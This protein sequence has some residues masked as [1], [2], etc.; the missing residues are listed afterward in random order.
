[1]K[2]RPNRNVFPFPFPMPSKIAPF[3]RLYSFSGG[4]SFPRM[5]GNKKPT[6]FLGHKVPW[7]RS[8]FRSMHGAFSSVSLY[9]STGTRRKGRASKGKRSSGSVAVPRKA[10]PREPA[11]KVEGSGV[12]E[13][14]TALPLCCRLAPFPML[15]ISKPL[16]TTMITK[17]P[18]LFASN[19]LV[20]CTIALLL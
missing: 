18:L 11:G 20:C 7:T 15:P 9:T 19:S 3:M 16:R 5:K 14:L 13:G 8:H 2:H 10:I 4:L 6:D 17:Y 1:M 12:C